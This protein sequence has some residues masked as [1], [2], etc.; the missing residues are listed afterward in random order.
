MNLRSPIAAMLWENWR[1]T[2]IEAAQRTGLGLVAGSAALT[3]FDAG[4]TYA[5][6]ILILC[7]AFIW[8]SV[9][10]LNGGRFMDG[11]KPGF[12]LHLLYTRPIPT[13]VFV[14]VAM[15]YDAISCVA[16][17]LASAALLGLAFGQPLPLFSVALYLVAAH[18]AYACVQWS[19]RNRVVQ[20]VGSIA[21]SWPLFFLLK[22]RVTPSLQVEFS[23]IDDAVLILICVVSYGLT[24]A[25]VARQ[26]CG[27]SIASDAPAKAGSGG[28]PPWLINFFRLPC[29]TSSATRAQVW[30]ELRCSGLP[31][32]TIGL[33]VA[34][35]IFLLFAASILVVPLRYVAVPVAM[36]SVPVVLFALGGNAF[37]I[38]RKQGRTYASAFELTQPYGT[39]QLV[40]L[41][42]LVRA[43][44]LLVALIAIGVS[45]WISSAFLSAWGA[46][47]PEEGKDAIPGLL[48]LRQRGVDALGGLTVYSY[49][50][51]AVIAS[52]A[53]A[54]M[55]AFQATREALRVRYPRRVLLAQCLPVALA[56]A[57]ILLTLVLRKG[58]GP[59]PLVGEII[60]VVF[61]IIGAAMVC[62]TI[63]LLWN[64]FAQ[65]VLTLRYACGALVSAAAFGAA[66]HAGIQP[67]NF[68]GILWLALGILMIGF[69]APWALSRV[70]H[71]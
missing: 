60:K 5:F 13:V 25:G 15:A 29:P 51:L 56:L 32:L 50:A 61:W 43:A 33:A 64:G 35:L 49:A 70:R 16:L 9:A 40:N 57:L 45:V 65:R 26:R 54:G 18:L 44:C 21:F 4:A 47:M 7:H 6:W 46:W 11:Y 68:D 3:F 34:M 23:L 10:K 28:Y 38:R 27:D 67:G 8:F 48:K 41:K 1:L 71:Q 17:Y 31:V 42:L 52:I 69:L 62:A 55:V 20:W 2:R 30:F 59:V 66:W 14:G 24:V 63:Y 36:C 53:V 12:P 19:T 37:G 22:Y 39:A 58:F